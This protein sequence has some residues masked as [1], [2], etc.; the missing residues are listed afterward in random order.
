MQIREN[1]TSIG[2]SYAE[3]VKGNEVTDK[4]I[5]QILIKLDKQEQSNKVILERLTKLQE[6][7]KKAN[8]KKTRMDCSYTS[9]RMEC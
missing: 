6:N 1:E 5:K 4:I 8:N 3:A 2:K 7:R 9:C